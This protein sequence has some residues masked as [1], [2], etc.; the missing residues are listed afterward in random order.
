MILRELLN[1]MGIFKRPKKPKRG[2]HQYWWIRFQYK[3][4]E[5]WESTH[6]IVGE[7]TKNQAREILKIRKNEIKTDKK[8]SVSSETITEY[9]GSPTLYEF[10]REYVQ[11]K[12]D[13]GKVSWERDVYSINNIVEF[14]GSDILLNEID[15]EGVS[16]YKTHRLKNRKPETINH[17]LICLGAIIN[18]ARD[19]G[20]FIGKNPVYISG[21][22]KYNRTK[23]R[24][25]TQKEQTLLLAASSEHFRFII[26]AALN[27]GMRRGELV[28]AKIEDI[29]L[30]QKYIFVPSSKTTDPRIIPLNKT[31][32][33]LVPILAERSECEFLFTTRL[34]KKYV[35]ANSI[36]LLFRRLCKKIELKNISFHSL[37]HTAATRM[38]EGKTDK[39]GNK[40][41]A[42]LVDVQLILGHK[43]P[44]TTMI[45]LNPEDSLKEA[46][47]LLD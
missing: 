35:D 28:K 40:R 14:F 7:I 39:N 19:W 3:G 15:A 47:S 22:L 18:L 21:L 12:K 11:Q 5:Y 2:Q 34:G 38:L 8:V 1:N 43:N 36:S 31:M 44:R 24:I 45:Y 23:R 16:K 9:P 4:K 41:R 6:R 33:D 29:N 37:R 10:S 30:E 20:R 46:V 13:E 17:E 26:V 27:T 25:L 42:S 32:L